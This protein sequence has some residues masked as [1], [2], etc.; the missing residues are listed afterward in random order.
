MAFSAALMSVF[1]EDQECWFEIVFSPILQAWLSLP[2]VFLAGSEP[3]Q[4]DVNIGL[5]L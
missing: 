4:E 3:E 2:Q 1:P 5:G